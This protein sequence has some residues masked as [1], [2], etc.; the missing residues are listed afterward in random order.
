MI[1]SCERAL[2][3]MNEP[4]AREAQMHS[5]LVLKVLTFFAFVVVFL[6]AIR[7]PA[8]RGSQ[9][10]RRGD[11]DVA[12]LQTASQIGFGKRDF[13]A[14]WRERIQRRCGDPEPTNMETPC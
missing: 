12:H 5:Q 10:A 13:E 9:W 3:L 6:L 11:A 8:D 1:A 7:G 14:L 2:R 4:F